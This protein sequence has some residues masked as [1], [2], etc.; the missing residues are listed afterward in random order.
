MSELTP[1]C[2]CTYQSIKYR[3]GDKK[4]EL[5]KSADGWTE[6]YVA[7]IMVASFMELTESCAC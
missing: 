7:G 6:C 3:A 2:Y 5:K 1:C 4:V